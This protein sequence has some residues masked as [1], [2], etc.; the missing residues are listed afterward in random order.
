MM[1]SRNLPFQRDT[2]LQQALVEIA[3]ERI[4]LVLDVIPGTKMLTLF[5]SLH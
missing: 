1:L 4:S 3:N 2:T 5:L